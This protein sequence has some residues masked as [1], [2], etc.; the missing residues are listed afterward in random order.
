MYKEQG[1]YDEAEKHLGEALRSTRL[2]RG[3]EHPLTLASILHLA[4][5]H[6]EQERYDEAEK[7]LLEA[8]DGPCVKLGDIHPQTIK[9][10]NNL[11]KLYEAWNKPEEAE[12]WRTKLQ[13]TEAVDE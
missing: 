11:N 2:Q 12:N 13:Q 4:E 8:I 3:N 5:L 1:R 6:I 10:I 7:L 9:S